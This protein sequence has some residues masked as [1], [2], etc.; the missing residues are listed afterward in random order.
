MEKY[1]EQY[2][3]RCI[4]RLKEWGASLEGWYCV[5]MYDMADKDE[6]QEDVALSAC[7]LCDYASVR[8]SLLSAIYTAFELADPISQVHQG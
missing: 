3:A 5:R 2:K 8:Y 7:E 4:K 6:S 1:S